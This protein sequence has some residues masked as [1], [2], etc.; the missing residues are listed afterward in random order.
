MKTEILKKIEEIQKEMESYRSARQK[1]LDVFMLESGLN[2][3]ISE[4]NA[5]MQY[6]D[7]QLKVLKELLSP[8]VINLSEENE[9]IQ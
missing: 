4:T 8:K 7:G 6:F 3:F 1:E 5:K 2:A 9:S